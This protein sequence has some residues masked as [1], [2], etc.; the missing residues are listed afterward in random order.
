[1]EP[2]AKIVSRRA[3][4]TAFDSQRDVHDIPRSGELPVASLVRDGLRTQYRSGSRVDPICFVSPAWQIQ[5]P[6]LLV[7]SRRYD[8]IVISIFDLAVMLIQSILLARLADAAT[9]GALRDF[10][11][12]ETFVRPHFDEI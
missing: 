10:G 7:A 2:A 6:S 11:D 9:I 1:M 5:D 4:F 12:N 8:V 3:S